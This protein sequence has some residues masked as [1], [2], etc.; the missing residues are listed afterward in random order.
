[1]SLAE[2]IAKRK[3]QERTDVARRADPELEARLDKFIAENP[4]L[5]EYY[6]A[7]SKEELV[8]SQMRVRMA[9]EN[10]E[11]VVRRDRVLEQWV[12]ENPEIVAKVEARFKNEAAANRERQSIN[13]AKTETVKQGMR[14]PRMHL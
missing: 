12:K 10:T 7:M 5:L 14:A 9:Q 8:Q 13:V 4:T 6:N 2:E 11:M 3:A 1:M